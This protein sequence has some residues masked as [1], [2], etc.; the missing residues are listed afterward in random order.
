[1]NPTALM[2]MQDTT[3]AGEDGIIREDDLSLDPSQ[4]LKLH[5]NGDGPRWPQSLPRI[6]WTCSGQ[7]LC[8]ALPC[9]S[10]QVFSHLETLPPKAVF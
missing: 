3:P 6:T 4:S 1:M 7:P 8:L 10:Q 9:S 5:I 2:Q